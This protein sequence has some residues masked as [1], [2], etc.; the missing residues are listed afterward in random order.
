MHAYQSKNEVRWLVNS[1]APALQQLANFNKK[2]LGTKQPEVNLNLRENDF[3]LFPVK[4]KRQRDDRR[5][6]AARKLSGLRGVFQ[7]DSLQPP[8]LPGWLNG[9]W[10]FKL[11]AQYGQTYSCHYIM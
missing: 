1:F 11:R 3:S 9:R 7:A 6:M 2:A 8:A 10:Q 5:P 4:S